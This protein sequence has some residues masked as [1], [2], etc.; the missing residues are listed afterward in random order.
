MVLYVWMLFVEMVV[1]WDEKVV[2]V[3]FESGDLVVKGFDEKLV[4]VRIV[5][6]LFCG[7]E[8]E[9]CFGGCLYVVWWL[10]VM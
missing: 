8:F 1:L 4:G 3:F 5:F 7:C 9:Y 2:V 6:F 10:V